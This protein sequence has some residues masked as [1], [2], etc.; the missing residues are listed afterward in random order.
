MKNQVI[1]FNII[2]DNKKEIFFKEYIEMQLF[3]LDCIQDR[4]RKKLK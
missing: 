3:S 2:C 4:K 1:Q